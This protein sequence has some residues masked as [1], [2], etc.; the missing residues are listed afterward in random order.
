M[1]EPTTADQARAIVYDAYTT[2]LSQAAAAQLLEGRATT[3]WVAHE[4]AAL[5][6]RGVS[7]MAGQQ[8]LFDTET[9]E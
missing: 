8:T 9:A 5:R 6:R 1:T 7:S 3:A 4:Y 2:G